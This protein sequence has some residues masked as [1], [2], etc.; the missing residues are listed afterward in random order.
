MDRAS[1]AWRLRCARSESS[2][3]CQSHG[4]YAEGPALIA[5]HGFTTGQIDQ[6]SFEKLLLPS[7]MKIGLDHG[8]GCYADKLPGYNTRKLSFQISSA[9][10]SLLYSILRDAGLSC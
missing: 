10:K 6:T 5:D 1:G 8:M 9:T 3:R 2:G 7:A 4:N